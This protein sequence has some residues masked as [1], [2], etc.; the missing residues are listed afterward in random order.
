MNRATIS[1]MI[2]GTHIRFMCL[3]D[4]EQDVTF[5]I[6]SAPTESDAEVV[7]CELRMSWFNYLKFA[8]HV[9]EHHRKVWGDI[10]PNGRSS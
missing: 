2:E 7:L 1:K 6:R 4:D 8:D 3:E 5:Q 9:K 10:Y